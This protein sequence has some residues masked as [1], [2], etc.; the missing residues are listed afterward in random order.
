MTYLIYIMGIGGQTDGCNLL[1]T[2][3]FTKLLYFGRRV[4]HVWHVTYGHVGRS[5]RIPSS[6]R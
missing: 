6:G 2:R 3:S 5:C 1:R 4:K